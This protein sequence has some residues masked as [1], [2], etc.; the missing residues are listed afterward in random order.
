MANELKNAQNNVQGIK[1]SAK[2]Q[3]INNESNAKPRALKNLANDES[4]RE[5]F[6]KTAALKA[7]KT[8]FDTKESS[9]R[10]FV[11][12]LGFT[13][14]AFKALEADALDVHSKSGVRFSTWETLNAIKRYSVEKDLTGEQK[15]KE[16]AKAER[17]R[18]REA[19]ERIKAQQ[20]AE[21]EAAKA[22]REAKAAAHVAVAKAAEAT[23]AAEAADAKRKADA[24]A[25]RRLAKR[26]K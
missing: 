14:N 10:A 15:A 18:L 8:A 23:R 12:S 26:N 7:V 5:M 3:V 6:S 13:A 9:T 25:A 2:A 16:E 19:K 20:K 17:E 4:K 11:L 1:E 21:R 22:E 24:K